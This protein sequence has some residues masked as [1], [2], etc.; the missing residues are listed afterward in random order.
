MVATKKIRITSQK[1]E[2]VF[3]KVK[4]EAD[5]SPKA[6]NWQFLAKCIRAYLPQTKEEDDAKLAT[7][8]ANYYKSLEKDGTTPLIHVP[9]PVVASQSGGDMD[10]LDGISFDPNE[11]A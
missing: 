7:R 2:T 11:D 6:A 3:R 5:K 8:V 4:A 1:F 10:A 9:L